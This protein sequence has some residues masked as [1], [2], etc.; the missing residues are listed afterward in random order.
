MIISPHSDWGILLVGL[1]ADE[2]D[3]SSPQIHF[4][5][6]KVWKQ[7]W[8]RLAILNPQLYSVSSTK[9]QISVQQLLSAMEKACTNMFLAHAMEIPTLYHT[10]LEQI[11]RNPPSSELSLISTDALYAEYSN[12][13]DRGVFSAILQY[14]HS[15]GNIV[16]LEGGLVCTDPQ[17]IPKLA[18]R[19]ISP[20]SVRAT[21]VR[22][23][24]VQILTPQDI[25]YLL[26]VNDSD[27]RYILFEFS[28]KYKHTYS[29]D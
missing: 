17:S 16:C 23:Q 24:N 11:Q 9:S 10:M 1:R 2:Q 28:E 12:G 3:L 26:D 18:A 7:I 6:I 15:I 21:L 20:E 29:M 8:P 27:E 4:S 5:Q 13:V 19:F 22:K 14:F 25:G